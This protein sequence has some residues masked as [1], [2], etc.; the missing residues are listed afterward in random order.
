MGTVVSTFWSI[1]SPPLPVPPQV[2]SQRTLH[3][4]YVHQLVFPSFFFT[5]LSPFTLLSLS[6]L[7]LPPSPY[8]YS[9]TSHSTTVYRIVKRGDIYRLDVIGWEGGGE[10]SEGDR[11]GGIFTQGANVQYLCRDGAVKKSIHCFSKWPNV[12]IHISFTSLII[13]KQV[14]EPTDFPSS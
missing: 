9:H 4:I 11:G 1:T 6:L 12:Y 5:V 3:L 14:S 13:I 8:L 10:G 2:L 7:S